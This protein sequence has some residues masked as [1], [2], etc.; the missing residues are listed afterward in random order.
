[1]RIEAHHVEK[2][3]DLNEEPNAARS[4]V[5][6]KFIVRVLYEGKSV[7]SPWKA[8]LAEELASLQFRIGVDKGQWV[9]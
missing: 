3:R 2:R 8:A 1:M 4:K 5:K 9:V 6:R 7:G